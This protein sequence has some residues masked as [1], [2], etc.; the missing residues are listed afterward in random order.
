LGDIEETMEHIL[1]SL[2][3]RYELGKCSRRELVAALGAVLAA[4]LP[5]EAAVASPK[6]PVRCRE[7]NH[8]TLR[9]KD[10]ARSRQ[11][12]ARVLGL[13]GFDHWCVGVQG[14]TRARAS[15]DDRSREPWRDTVKREGLS[16]RQDGEDPTLYVIDPDGFAV[17]LDPV[18]ARLR[19]GV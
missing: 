8:V 7:L 18:Q 10:L 5:T 19:L 2:V 14:F 11:F 15:A 12:Y 13:P 9:V 16:L 6:L 17:Q 4:G 3:R 1:D